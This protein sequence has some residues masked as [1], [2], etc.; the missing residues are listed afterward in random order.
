[1]EI[2][3]EIKKSAKTKSLKM[4]KQKQR[5]LEKF[6]KSKNKRRQFEEK[7]KIISKIRHRRLGKIMLVGGDDETEENDNIDISLLAEFDSDMRPTRKMNNESSNINGCD[8]R[9]Y[10]MSVHDHTGGYCYLCG[11][12]YFHDLSQSSYSNYWW[13]I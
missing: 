2:D 9:P 8:G 7:K 10:S 12:D 11:K 5:K 6:L 4:T 13:S 3:F 1:M